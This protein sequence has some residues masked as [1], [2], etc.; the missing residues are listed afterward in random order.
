MANIFCK[1]WFP[2]QVE[3]KQKLLLKLVP[4]TTHHN[5]CQCFLINYFNPQQQP[6]VNQY[7][8]KL[9]QPNAMMPPAAPPQPGNDKAGQ[10]GPGSGWVPPSYLERVS[11]IYDYSADKDDELS[12]H[13][14]SIIYVRID[15][16]FIYSEK[17]PKI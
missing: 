11:A 7:A 4:C 3:I 13:E 17:A 9:S 15:L 6:P 16:K 5:S 12:F 14:G 10:P 2:F 1:N 8:R